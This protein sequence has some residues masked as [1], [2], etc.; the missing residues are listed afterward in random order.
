VTTSVVCPKCDLRVSRGLSLRLNG[1]GKVVSCPRQLCIVLD[2]HTQ[3]V[4]AG[5]VL[6]VLLI[7]IDATRHRHTV[8]LLAPHLIVFK[9]AKLHA[10]DHT[11]RLHRGEAPSV[12]VT[13]GLHLCL[14][15]AI[16][17][18]QPRDLLKAILVLS[19]NNPFRLQ[20]VCEH[21]NQSGVFVDDHIELLWCADGLRVNRAPDGSQLGILRVLGD[22]LTLFFNLDFRD[23]YRDPFDVRNH[24]GLD[25]LEDGALHAV[26]IERLHVVTA[27]LDAVEG[28]FVVVAH[29]FG[30]QRSLSRLSNLLLHELSP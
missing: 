7:A 4:V 25:L 2:R 27:L 17:R 19:R 8:S 15:F 11:N 21:F 9:F 29:F 18:E 28:I 6:W 3:R 10:R 20:L 13:S 26:H 12:V 30:E 1:V 22:F 14:V 24:L 23:F 16:A 5:A